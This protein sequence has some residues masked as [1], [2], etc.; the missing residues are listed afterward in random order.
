MWKNLIYPEL[1][2]TNITVFFRIANIKIKILAFL[3]FSALARDY[4]QTA[5]QT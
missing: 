1:Y 2:L 3:S 4:G 5:D